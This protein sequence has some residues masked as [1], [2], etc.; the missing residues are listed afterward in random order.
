MP[1]T[2]MP[3]NV[4]D[5][6]GG[7]QQRVNGSDDQLG[8][9]QHHGHAKDNGTTALNLDPRA[10]ASGVSSSSSSTWKAGNRL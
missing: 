4:S 5:R 6:P 9:E 10:P 2:A 7:A 3:R 1:T 8:Y